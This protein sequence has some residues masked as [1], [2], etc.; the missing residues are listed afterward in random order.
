[1]NIIKKTAA[2]GFL[3]FWVVLII[4]DITYGFTHLSLLCQ[5]NVPLNQDIFIIPFILILI[6]VLL[7]F[8]LLMIK[9]FIFSIDEIKKM[10]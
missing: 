8:I 10:I 7:V 3:S 5:K 4:V 9:A 1:M 2:I 6:L